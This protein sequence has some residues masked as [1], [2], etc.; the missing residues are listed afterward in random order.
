VRDFE[1]LTRIA[2]G[3]EVT[4]YTGRY[5]GF[6]DRVEQGVRIRGLGFGR[7]NLL[8]RLTYA[9]SANVRVLFDGAD[10]IVNGASIFAP[11]LLGT[12]RGRRYGVFMHHFI[13]RDSLRKY[14]LAGA[15][16]W[17][18]EQLLMRTAGR[19]LVVNTAVRDR[20]LQVNPRAEV[21][22]TANGFSSR[23]LDLPREPAT[24]PFVLFVGR[25]DVHMKGLDL[26][27]PA[28]ADTLA[29][30]GIDLVLAGRASA[31]DLEKVR[32]LVPQVPGGQVRLELDV[33]EARKAELM[34]TCLFFASPSRF[35]GFGIAA[36]EANA[37]GCAVL[38]T[39]TDGFRDSLALGETA[40]SIPVEDPAALRAGLERLA[41]DEA[42]RAS[43]GR[44][45]RERARGFSWDSIAEK[46]W[47]W[48]RSSAS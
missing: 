10:R 7:S 27:I 16:P 3:V 13:G 23:L 35:E 12:L 21:L 24:P 19:Y 18:C 48:I 39:D 2:R 46:E 43:L 45:G 41:D 28:W 47:N 33:P 15:L 26:L 20:I 29:A 6:R 14:G 37:A 34:A 30:R 44:K 17:L 31:A 11:V 38:A 42:L 9:L 22:V 25:F 8:C 4:L 5:P 1:V 36:L 32:A 40:L